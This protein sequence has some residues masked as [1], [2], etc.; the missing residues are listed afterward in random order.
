MM[1]GGY[2]PETD[3]SKAFDILRWLWKYGGLRL[4][5]KLVGHAGP[6]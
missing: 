1:V 2:R 6:G 3:G 4:R 5:F